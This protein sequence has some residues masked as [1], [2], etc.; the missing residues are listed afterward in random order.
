[1]NHIINSCFAIHL[2]ITVLSL[3]CLHVT[4]DLSKNILVSPNL[5]ITVGIGSVQIRG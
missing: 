3:V 1:M 2:I 4:H 5:G